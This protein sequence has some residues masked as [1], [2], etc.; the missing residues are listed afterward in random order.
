MGLGWTR[1]CWT[2]PLTRAALAAG[3][4]LQAGSL[5]VACV[6][7]SKPCTLKSL[8]WPKK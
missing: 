3:C 2:T 6:R 7:F 4:M 8:G 1:F 5:Q